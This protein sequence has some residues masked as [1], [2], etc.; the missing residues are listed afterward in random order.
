MIA[1]MRELQDRGLEIGKDYHIT[2]K[3]TI[4]TPRV[5]LRERG[6]G[7]SHSSSNEDKDMDKWQELGWMPQDVRRKKIQKMAKGFGGRLKNP[8]GNIA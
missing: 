4:T 7:S 1:G 5:R 6:T 8:H 3:D 2:E